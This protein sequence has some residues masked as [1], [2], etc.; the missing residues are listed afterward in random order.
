MNRIDG[1]YSM[2]C[3]HQQKRFKFLVH[4]PQKVHCVNKLKVTLQ[5][6]KNNAHK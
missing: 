3:G 2:G 1:R 6:F 5:E 4:L